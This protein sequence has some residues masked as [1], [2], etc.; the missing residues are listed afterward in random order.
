[1]ITYRNLNLAALLLT[2]AYDSISPVVAAEDGAAPVELDAPAPIDADAPKTTPGGDD[3]STVVDAN[4]DSGTAETTTEATAS[5]TNQPEA[6]APET[7]DDAAAATTANDDKAIDNKPADDKAPATPSER[8]DKMYNNMAATHPQEAKKLKKE[9]HANQDKSAVLAKWSK[10]AIESQDMLDAVEELFAIYQVIK[11]IDG[12]VA[13][14]FE[15]KVEDE[16]DPRTMLEYAH[17]LLLK[18]L[19]DRKSQ[20]EMAKAELESVSV[21]LQYVD[22]EKAQQIADIERTAEDPRAQ[23]SEAYD[24]LEKTLEEAHKDVGLKPLQ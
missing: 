6:G 21:I 2:V 5:E 17:Q 23:I 18:T 8:F 13:A 10:T 19:K 24:L 20:I 7:A 14:D 9:Y 22:G 1:M 16:K 12:E 11:N 15:K 3:I 4:S